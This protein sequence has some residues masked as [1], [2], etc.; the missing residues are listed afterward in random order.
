MNRTPLKSK[1]S[2]ELS[3]ANKLFLLLSL[4]PLWSVSEAAVQVKSIAADYANKKVTFSVSWAADTRA[5][6]LSKVWV[7][8]DYTTVTNPNTVSSA[9]QRAT[10]ASASATSGV[11]SDNNGQGVYLQG[12]DG[13]FSA[14]VTVTL[15]GV[16]DKFN[17]CAVATDYPPNALSID[18][19]NTY[20]LH[21]TKPFL[22]NGNIAVDASTYSGSITTFSDATSCPG[23][24]ASVATGGVT[25]ANSNVNDLSS[26]YVLNGSYSV[27]NATVSGQGFVYSSSDNSPTTATGSQ[28]H[29][30]VGSSTI[31]YSWGAA[32]SSTT[33]YLRAY[34][35]VNGKI[36]YGNVQQFK[37][38]SGW[39]YA[40]VYSSYGTSGYYSGNN[41]YNCEKAMLGTLPTNSVSQQYQ[42]GGYGTCFYWRAKCSTVCETTCRAGRYI[43]GRSR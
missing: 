31:N 23:F 36:V 4:L 32:T 12:T 38:W 10:V 29:A 7:F 21:G 3:A 17:W 41:C 8:V 19:S 22:V 24:I 1:H 34:A 39:S 15:S 25:G 18:G 30:T 13:A 33:F 37:T 20:T 28:I 14:T 40:G 43:N 11:V 6:H 42:W 35:V 26:I 5:T 16:P 27:V 2:R 9:W